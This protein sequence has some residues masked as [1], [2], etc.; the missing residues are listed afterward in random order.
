MLLVQ[1]HTLTHTHTR[2]HTHTHTHTHTTTTTIHTHII[3]SDVGT[4]WGGGISEKEA[5]HIVWFD[6]THTHTHVSEPSFVVNIM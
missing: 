2:A 3:Y 5:G 1:R 6:P 4:C